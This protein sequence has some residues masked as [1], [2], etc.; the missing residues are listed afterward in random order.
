MNIELFAVNGCDVIH[1]S[2]YFGMGTMLYADMQLLSIRWRRAYLTW[3]ENKCNYYCNNI[4]ASSITYNIRLVVLGG[5]PGVIPELSQLVFGP[6]Q[7]LW[8]A[9]HD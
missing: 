8:K 7:I 1:L 4:T 3:L 5:E 9:T 6:E 2:S